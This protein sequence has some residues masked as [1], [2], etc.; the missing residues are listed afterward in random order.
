MVENLKELNGLNKNKE[1][2]RFQHLNFVYKKKTFQLF[3]YSIGIKKMWYG[4]WSQMEAW[5]HDTS[6]GACDLEPSPHS[7]KV[8]GFNLSGPFWKEF[9]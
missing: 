3:H 7:K 1:E 5:W 9:W 8:P 6:T 2:A 4:Y